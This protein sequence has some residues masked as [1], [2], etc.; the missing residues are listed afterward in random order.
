VVGGV[1]PANANAVDEVRPACEKYALNEPV[2]SI[3]LPSSE[4]FVRRPHEERK[5]D[6]IC[7]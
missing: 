4:G 5:A 3:C 7:T 2:T 1:V 6:G